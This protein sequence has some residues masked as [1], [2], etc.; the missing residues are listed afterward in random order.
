MIAILPL[1]DVGK[2][3]LAFA[4]SPNLRKL[5]EFRAHPDAQ[6]PIIEQT[7]A[8]AARNSFSCRLM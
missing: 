4:S 7:T 5:A 3:W 6:V 8:E 2:H 1:D